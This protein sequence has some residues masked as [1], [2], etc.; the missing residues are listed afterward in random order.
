M[1]M[2]AEHLGWLQKKGSAGEHNERNRTKEETTN[3]TPWFVFTFITAC[4]SSY[5][6]S[7][8]K[9]EN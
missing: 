3:P 1:R 9:Y 8:I 6:I 5:L 4:R 7:Q 2:F